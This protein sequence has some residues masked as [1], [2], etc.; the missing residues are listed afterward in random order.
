M[1]V[2]IVIV[3][4]LGPGTF[5]LLYFLAGLGIY[6]PVALALFGGDRLCADTCNT[7]SASRVIPHI[8][9]PIHII[10]IIQLHFPDCNLLGA[11]ALVCTTGSLCQG[12]VQELLVSLFIGWFQLQ[13]TVL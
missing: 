8:L 13:S 9:V 1:A 3:C 6:G 11:V 12:T 7:R 2:A 5:D 4:T 10:Y